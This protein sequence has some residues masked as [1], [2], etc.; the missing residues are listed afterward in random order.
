MDAA[1]ARVSGKQAA[2]LNLFALK[3]PVTTGKSPPSRLQ[4]EQMG[5]RRAWN[6]PVL[7]TAAPIEKEMTAMKV[8]PLHD[9]ILLKRIEEKES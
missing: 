8:R 5:S 3:N 7:R 4:F 2:A 1:L 9:R 6:T